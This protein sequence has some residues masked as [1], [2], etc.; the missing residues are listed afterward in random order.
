[1]RYRTEQNKNRKIV[2][3]KQDKSMVKVQ[4]EELLKKQHITPKS[5]D[6]ESVDSITADNPDC[7]PCITK[8]ADWDSAYHHAYVHPD[9]KTHKKE[10]PM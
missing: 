3:Y 7:Q 5:A 4:E 2:D 10:I 6:Y 8:I 1:M 9:M